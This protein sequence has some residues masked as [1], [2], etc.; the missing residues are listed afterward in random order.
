MDVCFVHSYALDQK[1]LDCA[2]PLFHINV[3]HRRRS[4]VVHGFVHKNKGGRRI[5]LSCA[6]NSL[7]VYTSQNFCCPYFKKKLKLRS[8]R[9]EQKHRLASMYRGVCANNAFICG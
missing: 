7:V 4:F 8:E 3:I 5:I 6:A 1:T 2:D 9:K